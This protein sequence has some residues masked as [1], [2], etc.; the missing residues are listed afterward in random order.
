MKPLAKGLF[1]GCG[2]VVLLG[3]L[4]VGLVVWYVRAHGGEFMAEGQAAEAAGAQA[5]VG[6]S[7][8]EC[9]A[10]ALARFKEKRGI[11]GGVHARLWLEAC[12]RAS[13]A[14]AAFCATVPPRSEFTRTVAWSVQQCT[15][16][17]LGG[18]SACSSVLAGAQE[19]C[20]GGRDARAP[21]P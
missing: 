4:A 7:G 21:A 14:D 9:I 1:I 2:S 15:A 18:D 10:G 6:R 13:E 16:A 8:D 20:A 12:L 5:G 3:L 19:H 17:G 11:T